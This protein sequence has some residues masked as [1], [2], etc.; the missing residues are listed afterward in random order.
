M[1]AH[2]V[3]HSTIVCHISEVEKPGDFV[4]LPWKV[5]GEIAV[6]NI[7]GEIVGWDNRCPHRG[8]RIYTTMSGNARPVCGYHHRCATPD[9]MRVKYPIGHVNGWVV[10]NEE[11]D[12]SEREMGFFSFHC[13]NGGTWLI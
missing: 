9:L 12:T 10:A 4:V 13:S 3:K 1:G 7:D 11:G 8:M 6:S 5:D 2:E